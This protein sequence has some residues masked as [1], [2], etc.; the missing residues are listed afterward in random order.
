MAEMIRTLGCYNE[1]FQMASKEINKKTERIIRNFP[2]V[3]KIVAG[4]LTFEGI[5]HKNT[6]VLEIHYKESE[7]AHC[8]TL[9]LNG[10]ASEIYIDYVEE[11]HKIA[12]EFMEQND[13]T[14]E[15]HV[16]SWPQ[17]QAIISKPAMS[18]T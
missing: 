9:P 7:D 13:F 8:K 3:F 5:T 18:R 16:N 1:G 6:Y 2:A 12:T 10:W 11:S 15:D 17:F 4:P 14:L